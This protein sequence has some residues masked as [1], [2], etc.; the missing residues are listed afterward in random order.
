MMVLIKE[1]FN[2]RTYQ[3]FAYD[4]LVM[5]HPNL[6]KLMT[7]AMHYVDKYGLELVLDI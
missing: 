2:G 3:L 4:L 1:A 5:Q 6:D 7:L